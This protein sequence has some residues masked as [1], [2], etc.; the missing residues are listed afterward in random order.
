MEQKQLMFPFN[1]MF[2]STEQQ[3]ITQ[4]SPSKYGNRKNNSRQRRIGLWGVDA[5]KDRR[6]KKWKLQ[7]QNNTQKRFDGPP[8]AACSCHI[9][10]C[11]YV[12]AGRMP[13]W[14]GCTVAPVSHAVICSLDWPPKLSNHNRHHDCPSRAPTT[15]CC[16]TVATWFKGQC[17][18]SAPSQL[19]KA[20]AAH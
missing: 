5:A 2:D 14:D 17:H 3:R 18:W 16:E 10:I 7:L 13:E 4:L 6:L 9:Y 1:Q 15:P 11:T 20:A 8:K 12:A 19:Q